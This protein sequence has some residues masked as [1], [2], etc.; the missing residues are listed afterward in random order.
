[1]NVPFGCGVDVGVVV[2]FDV[3]VAVGVAVAFTVGVDV[4]VVVD[5]DVG[6]DVVIA[7]LG[8]GL[9]VVS[10]TQP[11]MLMNSTAIITRP[12]SAFECFTLSYPVYTVC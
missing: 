2:G 12:K 10:E 3:G 7:A 8:L 5:F 9:T 1:M 4:G 11:H 6:V